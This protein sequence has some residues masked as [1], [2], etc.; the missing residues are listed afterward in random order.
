MGRGERAVVFVAWG[1]LREVIRFHIGPICVTIKVQVCWYLPGLSESSFSVQI[2]F[3]MNSA[4][5]LS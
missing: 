3:L 2:Y 1:E 4:L 5:A